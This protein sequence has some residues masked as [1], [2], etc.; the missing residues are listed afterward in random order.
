MFEPRAAGESDLPQVSAIIPTRNE[1]R[2]LPFI[3]KALA[4]LGVP[5][6]VIVSDGGSTDATVRIAKEAGATVVVASGGRG[7]QM[8]EGA[9]VARAPLLVFLHADARLSPEAV[10]A[11]ERLAGEGFAGAAAFRFA[12]ADRRWEYRVLE[13]G[14]RFR[15]RVLGLPYGDQ[16]LIIGA[17]LYRSAGEYPPIPLMEDVALARALQPLGGIRILPT[18]LPVSSRRWRRDGPWR[19]TAGNLLL[20]VRYLLGAA[21]ETLAARYDRARG[22][23]G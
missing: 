15:S 21:P 18:E 12:I 4:T 23:S 11:I 17:A 3:L 9:R 6:E 13:A 14:T 1:A 5:H 20:L 22:E 2:E 19:R 10:G 7:G 8:R 16:G